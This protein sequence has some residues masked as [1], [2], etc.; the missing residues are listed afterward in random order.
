MR[1]H[2]LAAPLVILLALAAVPARAQEPEQQQ[3][4]EQDVRPWRTRVAL[5]PQLVP[6]FPGASDVAIRPYIGV[7]RARG[8][9]PFKF[10]AADDTFGVAVLSGDRFS[11]GP[12]LGFE[13]KRSRSDTDDA[14]PGVDFSVEL[15]G[16]AQYQLSPAIRLRVE[17]RQGVSGHE[18]FVANLGADYVA[19]DGDR[20]LFSL[21]PRVTLTDGKYQRAYFGVAPADAIVA[22]LDAFRPDGG[23][24]AVGAAAGAIRQLTSRI[25]LMGYAKY[26]RLVSDAA[27][28]PVVRAFG[29]RN[30][31]SGGI[32][33]TYTFGIRD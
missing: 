30:Q 7:S 27:D 26:D 24:Q 22:G 9:D 15:G 5:G 12:S 33:L 20:W 18:G 13:G 28:S 2:A 4:Q 14:L 6:D 31:F 29:S 11:F 25:G 32:A 23:V 21:G 16:F 19:R 10:T 17:A 1:Y 8:D 3:E